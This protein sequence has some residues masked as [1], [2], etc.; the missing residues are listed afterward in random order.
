MK[1][2]YA[3]DIHGDQN[4]YENL[5]SLCIENK[6]N[7]I[8]VGGDLFIKNAPLRI[9]IQREFVSGYLK[10]YFNKLKENNINFICIVGNDDLNIP[11]KDYYQMIKE[12]PNVYD[13]TNRRVDIED[14]SFIGLQYVLDTPFKRKDNVASEKDFVMPKQ[15]HDD[16]YI[17]DC[18]KV[19]TKEEWESYF[20]NLPK[21]E[22]LLEKLPK[23]DK[24]TIYIFH[25]PPF[26]VGLDM[27]NDGSTV[28]SKAI[29]NFLEKSNALMSFHGHIHE[30]PKKSGNWFKLIGE[31]ISI[32]PGQ[33]EYDEDYMYYVEVDTD[34]KEYKRVKTLVKKK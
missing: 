3:C 10:E 24:E 30:S 14:I 32:Q 33:T 23:S 8:V 9:P 22:D 17:D 20:K 16:I 12:F 13:V 7:N 2:I 27:C 29:Y 15:F 31:T 21:M 18:Q 26:G 34:K 5:L 19:I 1:F 28:G 6:I 11:C 25:D 4:K